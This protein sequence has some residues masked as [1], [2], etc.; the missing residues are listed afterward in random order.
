MASKAQRFGEAMA[1]FSRNDVDAFG[2][3]LAD[4]VVWHWG[5]DSSVSGD[6]HGK[7]ATLELL[8]G[9]RELTGNHL[10]V[11]PLDMLE[12]REF[13]MSFTRVTGTK[14]PDADIDV[15]MADAVRFG[16]DGKVVE[17]WTLSNDQRA[18]DSFI[19]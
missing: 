8:R 3:I 4:D 6:Y 18:V 7:A 19:G 1:A 9:F 17:Y 14:G 15:I 5:G 13:L 12:G 11:E 16:A 2:D 10:T